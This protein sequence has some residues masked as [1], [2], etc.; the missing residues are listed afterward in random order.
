[1][2]RRTN[3]RS[4]RSNSTRRAGSSLTAPTSRPPTTWTAKQ[5][6]AFL[7]RL[8]GDRLEALWV[9][10][11]STGMRRASSWGCGGPTWTRTSSPSDRCASRTGA[12]TRSRSRRRPPLVARSRSPR[13]PSPRPRPTASARRPR[14]SRAPAYEDQGL[15][16]ADRIGDPLSPEMVSSSFRAIMKAAGLPPLIPHGR[17][18]SSSSASFTREAKSP[19]PR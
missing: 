14:H 18:R 13:E 15:V 10:A 9:L 19:P 11:A 5:D 12:P 8:T 7:G 1:M 6:A 16:F 3:E 4:R 17:P 2:R